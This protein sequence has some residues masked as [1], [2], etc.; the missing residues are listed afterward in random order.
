VD[1]LWISCG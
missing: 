1:N